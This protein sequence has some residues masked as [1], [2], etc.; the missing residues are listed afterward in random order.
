MRRK[1]REVTDTA[2]IDETLQLCDSCALALVDGAKP[3]VI[4]LNYGFARAENGSLK[5]Y[6]HCARQGKKLDLIR[7]NPSAAFIADTAHELV[8]G[9]SGCD[10]GMKYRSVAGKGTLRFAVDPAEK[11]KGLD[12]LMAHHSG[13]IDF[14]YDER[15]FAMTE[16]LVL[17]VESCTGKEK[18]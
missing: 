4:T 14:S 17:E 18:K 8:T 3:Y 13:R 9:E 6:F 10:W 12:L 7:Q 2:W 1:D 5:L 16:V 15:V 11:K